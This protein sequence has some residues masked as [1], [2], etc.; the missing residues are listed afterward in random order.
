MS[1]ANL[2]SADGVTPLTDANNNLKVA[3]QAGSSTIGNVNVV[4]Q[5]YSSGIT[6]V[7]AASGNVA[8]AA[9][10]ATIA[11]VAARTNYLTGFEITSSGATGASVVVATI[12]GLL[13]GT[14]SYVYTCV[15]GVTLAN[16]PLVV[17]FNPP[18]VAS[19]VNTAI[20]VSLP[21]LGAGNTN[22]AV[23]AHGYTI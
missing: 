5:P 13:G 6:P 14:A 19:A 12:T 3:I 7:T 23:V 17:T 21:S 15:A 20:A 11:A 22:A 16:A 9:A 1:N 10:T 4:T 2:V 18:L 8:A